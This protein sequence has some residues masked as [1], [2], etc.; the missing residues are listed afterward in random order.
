MEK[1]CVLGSVGSP[2]CVA[3]T[4]SGGQECD[5]NADC[6]SGNCENDVCEPVEAPCDTDSDC[7]ENE[8]CNSGV[9]EPDTDPNQCDPAC[10]GGQTCVS[11]TC[12]EPVN[13]PSVQCT[14]VCEAGE[15]CDERGE[16]VPDC[17]RNACEVLN[18]FEN[19]CES[20]CG[21]FEKCDGSGVLPQTRGFC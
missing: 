20:T 7:N 15:R 4:A 1:G 5:E 17:Q 10:V 11:G 21:T 6:L 8:T 13:I 9:C 12:V 14:P 2:L 3:E 18:Q 16:C 19:A